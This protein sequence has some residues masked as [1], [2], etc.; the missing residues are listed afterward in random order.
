MT[1]KDLYTEWEENTKNVYTSYI[2]Y[3]VGEI[4][5]RYKNNRIKINP[6]F[7]RH[8]RWSL[9]QKSNFIESL[10]LDY[11]IPPIFVYMN[12]DKTELEV[13]DGL[14]RL[15]TIFE[16]VKVLKDIESPYPFDNIINTKIM[17]SLHNSN[18]ND[19]KKCGLDFILENRSIQLIVLAAQ[20]DL[21]VKYE[22]FRRLN[23]LSSA[24]S[25]QEVRNATLFERE[26]LIYDEVV[27]VFKNLDFSF[28]SKNDLTERKDL[29]LFLTFL[30]LDDYIN[31]KLSNEMLVSINLNNYSEILDDFSFVLINKQLSDGL[32]NFVKFLDQISPY[33]FKYYDKNKGKS[34]GQF[35]NFYFETIAS[36]YILNKNKKL[37]SSVIE[38][39][40]SVKYID[41][42]R[43]LE[44]TNPPAKTRLLCAIDVAKKYLQFC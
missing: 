20:S 42:Q 44:K 39:I 12:A 6:S 35:V 17:K 37:P 2:T 7:Q 15:A 40:V 36:I 31:N 5:N 10:L 29:E 24:L 19:F 33:D 18:W 4:I 43:N 14:Q 26:P 16:F 3:S 13:I 38:K 11:P 32:K 41:W 22:I 25:P 21:K 34:S 1:T 8:F 27:K 9:E 28:L 23:S 30:L